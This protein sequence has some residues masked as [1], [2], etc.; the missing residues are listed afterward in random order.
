MSGDTF[1]TDGM[2]VEGDNDYVFIGYT[3]SRDLF[4]ANYVSFI[5][6]EDGDDPLNTVF[7]V[8]YTSSHFNKFMSV[9]S[10]YE[11]KNYYVVTDG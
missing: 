10:I 2:I 8:G 3:E 1:I 7:Y 9:G 5:A 11:M 4:G 6:E